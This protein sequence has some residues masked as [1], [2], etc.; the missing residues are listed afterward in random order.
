MTPRFR[1]RN[2]RLPPPPGSVCSCGT[3]NGSILRDGIER[4]AGGIGRQH[5]MVAAPVDDPVA[6]QHRDRQRRPV[7]GLGARSPMMPPDSPVNR[8][9][10]SSVAG[11]T[12]ARREDAVVAV[13]LAHHAVAEAIRRRGELDRHVGRLLEAVEAAPLFEDLRDDA[14]L[15]DALDEIVQHHP[16]VVPGHDLARL[17]RRS[18]RSALPPPPA[19]RRPCCGT[20]ASRDGSARRRRFSSLR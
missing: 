8:N 16:L 15:G 4:H 18:R 9:S 11:D 1:L 17:A 13:D 19:G 3:T 2:G 5:F 12:A 7:G 6:R 14:L 20:S 10:S